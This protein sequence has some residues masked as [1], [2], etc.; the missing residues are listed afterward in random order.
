MECQK[1]YDL[2]GYF[3]N[4]ISEIEKSEIEQHLVSC[5]DCQQE[6]E[7]I[8][9]TVI[10]LKRLPEIEPSYDFT[11]KVIGY[12]KKKYTLPSSAIN[13]KKPVQA[14][15]IL[16]Y[17]LRRSSPWAISVTLHIM[18]LVAL[19]FIIVKQF[20]FNTGNISKGVESSYIVY[21]P[22]PINV[23]R[24]SIN[25]KEVFNRINNTDDK[26]I[27][28]IEGRIDETKR[29]EL[30]A[31]YDGKDTVKAVSQGIKWLADSQENVGKWSPQKY[32][33]REEYT[34]ALTGLSLL[35]FTAEGNTH[36]KGKYAKTVNR[37]VKYLISVQEPN[38][39][40]NTPLPK[41]RSVNYMYNHGI[42]TYALLEDY[43]I[44]HNYPESESNELTKTL[45]ESII[46]AVSFIVQSQSNN[47]GWG[48]LSNSQLPNTSVTVWQVQAL[49][50]ASM[51]DIPGVD[52]ALRKS[53]QWLGDVTNDN[54][55]VDYKESADYPNSPYALTASGITAYLWI[56]SLPV[57]K[58]EENNVIKKRLD[59]LYNKQIA[60]FSENLPLSK[61]A[62]DNDF[63]YWYWG[64]MVM[65]SP[66]NQEWQKWNA[67]I[68]E[69]LIKNQAE[70][71]TWQFNDKWGMFGGQLYTTTMAI[72]TLQVYYRYPPMR[73]RAS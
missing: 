17:Y 43:F 5:P 53:Y 29:E 66:D 65:I 19:A 12:V 39:L 10:S 35:C 40:L 61:S 48:Y 71:G 22:E 27:K 1:D 64:T 42:A 18:V 33:G 7:D 16:K 37:A 69:I 49:R 63:C 4:E 14:S 2:V 31:K 8:K 47:G 55:L 56:D 72:L 20:S 46:K 57:M 6:L 73:V 60:L 51:L 44:A 34:V 9:K 32:G 28:H 54:G 41:N 62:T 15:D 3:N 13:G 59:N 67:Q 36:V 45:G 11:A 30:L 68:K 38:G 23:P 26:I 52:N 25:Q 24:I 21:V 58:S 70:N 50:L